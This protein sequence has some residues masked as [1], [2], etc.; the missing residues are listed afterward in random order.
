[1]AFAIILLTWY[2]KIISLDRFARGAPA[3][4]S[5][6]PAPDQ[7]P[8]SPPEAPAPPARVA[9]HAPT[10]KMAASH[11]APARVVRQ[12]DQAEVEQPKQIRQDAFFSSITSV[13]RKK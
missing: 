7:G 6:M 1:M 2:S 11:S 3:P 5:D 13:S 10:K 8:P 4:P 9:R 12:V